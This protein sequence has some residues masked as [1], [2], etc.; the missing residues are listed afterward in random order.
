MLCNYNLIVTAL[1]FNGGDWGDNEMF[2][3]LGALVDYG[4][5]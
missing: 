1:L 3:D 5:R 2:V 4:S